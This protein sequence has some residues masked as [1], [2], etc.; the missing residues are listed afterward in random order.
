MPPEDE[1]PGRKGEQWSREETLFP[2]SLRMKA[3][4]LLNFVPVGIIYSAS[5][6]PTL[7][8]CNCVLLKTQGNMSCT[9]TFL[10][11]IFL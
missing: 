2:T 6:W 11:V 8:T 9:L 10:R 3:G 7:V 4:K 5:N 1:V